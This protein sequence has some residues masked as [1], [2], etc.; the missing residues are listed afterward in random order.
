MPRS[1]YLFRRPNGFYYAQITDPSGAVTLWRSTRSKN[2]DE[3]A[4]VV[5]GWLAGGLPV[6]GGRTKKRVTAAADYKSVLKFLKEGDI[7]E[8]Q[9][10]EI[11]SAL[12]ARNLLS[13]GVS[14]A[15]GGGRNLTEFLL[16]FWDYDNSLYLKDRRA[17]GKSISRRS[18]REAV[19]SVN[20]YWEPHFHGKTLSDITRAELRDFGLSLRSE[21]ASK[22]V[23]NVL[24]W[25]ASALRWAYREKM[26]PENITEGI[27]G[28]TGGEKKRDILTAAEVEK[29]KDI[30]HWENKKA[31]AAFRIAITSALRSG[32]IL[33]LRKEDIGEN[34][35]HVRHSYNRVEG[36]KSPKNG[37]ARTAYLLPDVRKLIMELLKETPD[38]LAGDKQF[39]FYSD[40]DPEKPCADMHLLRHLKKAIKNAGIDITGRRIDF[41]SCRHYV[42]TK[43]A[44]KTGDLRQAAKVGGHKNLKTTAGYADHVDE[45]EI[46]AMGKTAENILEFKKEAIA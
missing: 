38:D 8:T 20:K 7:D 23:N 30:K 9:A 22:T 24:H 43:W 4:A 3:A 34:V 15:K 41:H 28:F 45:D 21:L 1:F 18:C 25:G 10:L 39:V 35:I 29:L 37:E 13:F 44:D 46:A 26:I 12:K 16:E 42:L 33:A 32:E 40:I 17:H 27:G 2:R 14:A 5:G 6:C 36:L 19:Q 11:A 31:Y